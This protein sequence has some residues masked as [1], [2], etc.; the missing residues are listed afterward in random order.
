[1]DV[2]VAC[3]HQWL[4]HQYRCRRAHVDGI[5]RIRASCSIC[6]RPTVVRSS[7]MV[8]ACVDA[9]RTQ[10]QQQRVA[11]AA[12]PPFRT[13]AAF[14]T[15]DPLLQ[16]ALHV[17]QEMMV[18]AS[19]ST[20]AVAA[21]TTPPDGEMAMAMV[22]ASPPQMPPPEMVRALMY[23]AVVTGLVLCTVCVLG[24]GMLLHHVMAMCM[25]MLPL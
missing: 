14:D 3:L 4:L 1:M 22:M 5:D 16:F 15:N 25:W 13:A 23:R 6:R 21:T 17:V 9:W 18:H 2:H 8:E 20:S 7:E 12:T 11:A 19:S 10:Q 24:T